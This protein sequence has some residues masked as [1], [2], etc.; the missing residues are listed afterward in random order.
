MAFDQGDRTEAA[1]P[2]KRQEARDR[3]QVAR[4]TELTS[5]AVLLGAFGGL[6][7][8]GGQA[9]QLLLASFE[10]G[11]QLAR[12]LPLSIEDVRAYLLAAGLL[13]LRAAGPVLLA[14]ACCGVLANL[15]QVGFLVSGEAVGFKWERVNP[16]RGAQ[17]LFSSRGAVEALKASLKVAI[18]G[19]VAYRTLRPE[20]GRFP[21]LAAMELMDL[22]RWQLAVATRL[23]FRVLGVYTLLAAADYLYQRWEFE[24]GLRMSRSEI[25]E[26]S[27]QQEGNPQIRARI[28]SLQQERAMRQM[29]RDVATASVVVVNPTHIAIALR[30]DRGLRA[31]TVVAKGKRLI[32]ER[33]IALAREHGIP[34][35][36]DIPLARGLYK[37]VE[38]GGEIPGTFYRA[39]AKI[40][41][42]VMARDRRGVAA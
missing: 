10:R 6:A 25:Q 16:I 4:S 37:H 33:I 12:P 2:R 28:R 26:E 36:Q 8:A 19:Y 13:T 23:A 11:L 27:R 14:A 38:V 24:R 30:Y 9:G 34:V 17:Q 7:L 40:L 15:I 20:W 31:P 29:M 21:E 42:Y 22:L 35:I 18:L 1:T 3:G 5:A 41:A 32:A 39:V